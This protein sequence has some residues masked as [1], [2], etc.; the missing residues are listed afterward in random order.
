MNWFDYITKVVD[1][2]VKKLS[3]CSVTKR[4]SDADPTPSDIKEGGAKIWKNTSS[5]TVK[6]YYNDNGTLVSVTLS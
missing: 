2:R 1:D 3:C 6:L 4:V 5:G